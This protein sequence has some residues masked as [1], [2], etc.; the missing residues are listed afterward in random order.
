MTAS[1]LMNMNEYDLGPCPSLN[2]VL[3]GWCVLNAIEDI[4]DVEDEYRYFS[5]EI[6]NSEKINFVDIVC[7]TNDEENNFYSVNFYYKSPQKST[8]ISSYQAVCEDRLVD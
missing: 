7:H 8:L 2:W 5:F 3:G 1:Y 6:K 4:G